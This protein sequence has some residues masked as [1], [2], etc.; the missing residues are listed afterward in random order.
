M[1]FNETIKKDQ[2]WD[3]PA[4]DSALWENSFVKRPFYGTERSRIF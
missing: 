1:L 4:K 3:T 2:K